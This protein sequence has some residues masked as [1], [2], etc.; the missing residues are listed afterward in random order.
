MPKPGAV[1]ET[2]ELARFNNKSDIDNMEGMD[3]I[4]NKDGSKDIFLI[5]DDN[6]NPLQHTILVW[7]T[8]PSWRQR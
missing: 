6:F 7:L 2:T 1:L 3:V 8:L 4:H 5:S